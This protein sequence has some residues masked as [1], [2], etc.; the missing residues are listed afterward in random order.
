MALPPP[1]QGSLPAGWLAF[2]GRELNPLD[3]DERFQITCSSP[4]PGLTLTLHPTLPDPCSAQG[5]ASHPSLRAV[6]QRQTP[7]RQ[8]RSCSPTA[9]RAA[10]R[11]AA[12]SRRRIRSTSRSAN[13]VPTLRWPLDHHRDLRARLSAQARS[14]NN[15]DRYLMTPSPLPHDWPHTNRSRRH[16]TATV[17]PRGRPPILSARTP[18]TSPRNAASVRQSPYSPA[19]PSPQPLQ[20]KLINPGV[21]TKSP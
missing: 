19:E 6:R 3:R 20:S 11:S 10:K 5:P 14:G 15:Q 9:R 17:H 21:A 2:A 16:L 7:R 13:A 12:E 4:S 1:P 18:Q 8:Y